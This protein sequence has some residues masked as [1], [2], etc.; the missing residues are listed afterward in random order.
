MVE[1]RILISVSK[2]DADLMMEDC[3]ESYLKYHPEARR[4]HFTYAMMVDILVRFYLYKK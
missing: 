3:K 4:Q 1:K 2:E